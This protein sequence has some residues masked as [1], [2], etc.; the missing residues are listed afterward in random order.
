MWFPPFIQKYIHQLSAFVFNLLVKLK[1]F[2]PWSSPVDVE[3]GT[4][5][6]Q[7]G[8]ARAEAERR[9]ALALKALDQRLASKPTRPPPAVSG[10][11]EPAASA[12]VPIPQGE[13][14]FD[15]T[16]ETQS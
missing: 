7:P 12:P 2:R 6:N 16:Q 8:G 9:R 4:Y 13:V 14:V 3:S 5:T 15:A 10:D 11:S 1:L